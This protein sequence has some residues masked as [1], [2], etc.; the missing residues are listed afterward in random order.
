[1]SRFLFVVPPLAAHAYPAAAVSRALVR[2]GHEVGWVGSA[3]Y[4]RSFA[5]DHATVFPTGMR[6]Y[7]GQ[8][9]RGTRALKSLWEDFV[10]PY[11]RATLSAVDGA[12]RAF[13]PQVVAVDQ[14]AVAGAL[15]AQRH[16]LP[17]ASLAPTQMETARPYKDLPAVERWIGSHLTGLCHEAGVVSGAED[18]RFSPHLLVSFT[19]AALTGAPATAHHHA[20]VGPALASRPEVPDFPWHALDRRRRLVLVT[21]GT[22]ASD[23]ARG[24]FGRMVRALAPLAADVQA[25][26]HAPPEAVPD[27]PPNT[28]VVPRVPVLELLP[29]VRAVVCHGGMST[30]SEA[31]YHRVPV[32]VAPLKYDHP[33][34]AAQVVAAGAG[35]RVHFG[36]S[37]PEQLRAALTAVLERPE[38]GAGARRIAASFAAAGGAEAAAR[39]LAELA[40]T[41]RGS[42]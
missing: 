11:A 9:D 32:V 6:P 4:F 29:A 13:R 28:L 7:R 2:R 39:R 33:V 23:L 18:P 17:W 34:V 14:H 38:Y 24:F 40:G 42:A 1:V 16:G 30:V 26:L 21:A 31:L 36:R 19:T 8:R 37:T 20:L 25:V 12:V 35:T 41:P 22:L 10:T 5:D 15:V 3:R 27:P